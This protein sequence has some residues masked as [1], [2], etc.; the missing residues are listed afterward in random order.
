MRDRCLGALVAI[1]VS[2]TAAAQTTDGGYDKALSSS[3][4]GVAKAMH[5]T[6]RANLAE[7]AQQMSDA[8]YTF[9]PT[10]E[11][12][13]FGQLVGHVIN[14]NYFFCSQASGEKSPAT[15]NFETV[16]DKATLVKGLTDSLSYCDRIY[17]ATT[18]ATFNQP[19]KMASGAGMPAT[20][21]VRGAV[22]MFNVA[23]NNEHYG[24]VVVYMRLK[25][26]VPPST[27]RVQGSK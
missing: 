3:M 16:V 2:T 11:V 17:G 1:L 20:A 6:I 19:V 13:T 27:A 4:A 15:L 21:T 12:R 14:A 26:R 7:A 9:R 8:D 18:D 23:H 24:N 5:L 25:G 22:L 10:A